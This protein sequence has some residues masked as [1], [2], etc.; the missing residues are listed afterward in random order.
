MN[1]TFCSYL[2]D[3]KT[4]SCLLTR[5]SK[6]PFDHHTLNFSVVFAAWLCCQVAFCSFH[7]SKGNSFSALEFARHYCSHPGVNE[8]P[9]P[10]TACSIH[11]LQREMRAMTLPIFY[12][13]TPMFSSVKLTCHKVSACKRKKKSMFWKRSH[14]MIIWI[15]G[16]L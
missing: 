16:K 7:K 10:S 3:V 14:W 4:G 5:S 12:F 15:W 2:R 13:V 6:Q 1:T 8:P 11:R 9:P